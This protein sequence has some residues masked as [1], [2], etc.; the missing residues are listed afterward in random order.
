MSLNVSPSPGAEARVGP[1]PGAEALALAETPFQQ[2]WRTFR[3]DRLAMLGL[4]VLI[5]LIA[6]A[7]FGKLLTE[8]WVVF[9]PATVRL[10]D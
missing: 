6:L 2:V 9:V 10:P 7:F 1:V 4:V 5:L 3:K 8:L